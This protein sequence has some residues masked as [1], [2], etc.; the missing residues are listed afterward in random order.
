MD[1]LRRLLHE[2]A[3]SPAGDADL[4]DV[5]HRATR[6]KRQRR[7]LVVAGVSVLVVALATAVSAWPNERGGP[8]RTADETA[9][10]TPTEVTTS[11]SSLPGETVSVAPTGTGTTGSATPGTPSPWTVGRLT[12]LGNGDTVTIEGTGIPNG[13]YLVG[14]CPAYVVQTR[15]ITPCSRQ[16]H[17]V[18]DGHLEATV[19][20]GW[21]IANTDCGLAPG[22]CLVGA[23]NMTTSEPISWDL[24]FDPAR[25]PRIE[26]LPST[27]LVDDQVV[28]VRGYNL[29]PGG[30][31]LEECTEP[32][33]C[34][35]QVSVSWPDG[36]FSV[37]FTVSAVMMQYHH[38]PAGGIEV[39]CGG[40]C[41]IEL[42]A[43]DLVL[44][45]VLQFASSSSPTTS[46]TVPV[47]S[48]A[49]SSTTSSTS[50]AGTRSS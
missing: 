1:E 26:V 12:G 33:N 34:A 41:S 40:G 44:E 5:E 8:V 14:Q 6:H 27:G 50:A 43:S 22:S 15:D 9:T 49:P 19:T 4:V 35:S 11:G 13:V 42:A 45:V 39:V 18:V 17:T 47:T 24:A 10:T 37:P 30:G 7:V 25:R 16:S 48:T 3:L 21:W 28:E 2:S 31:T 38:A 32:M 20:V 36:S 46:S 23:L 29:G